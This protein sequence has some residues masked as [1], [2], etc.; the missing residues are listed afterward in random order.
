MALART[1]NGVGVS[2]TAGQATLL[3]LRFYDSGNRQA[4]TSTVVSET[5]AYAVDN[6]AQI[7]S[8][9]YNVDIFVGDP[10]YTAGLQYV[11]DQGALHFNSAGNGNTA[12]PPREVFEQSLFVANTDAADSKSFSSNYGE[13][14]DIA[15]P[16]SNIFSTHPGA[17]YSLKSGTSIAA[18]N[19]AGV[20]ALIWSH[21][22]TWT[23]E[24]VAAQ[25]LGTAD[26]IDSSNPDFVGLLGTGRVN[27][28][29]ALTS[30][31]GLPPVLSINN[32]PMDGESTD[33]A[34]VDEF[35]IS[36]DRIMEAAT[37]DDLSAY[38]LRSAGADR[39][40]DTLDDGLLSLAI[41]NNYEVG[42]NATIFDILSGP[43]GFGDYR[44]TVSGSILTDPFGNAIDGDADGSAGGDFTHFFSV[45]ESPTVPI[46]FAGGLNY[47]A[48]FV[49]VMNS[50]DQ[51]DLYTIPV[52]AGLSLSVVLESSDFQ[53]HIVVHDPTGAV[54]SDVIGDGWLVS[55][56]IATTIEGEYT[57]TITSEDGN[58]G[59]YTGQVILNA[60]F[61]FEHLDATLSNDDKANA[62][63]I[64]EHRVALGTTDADRLA[65][66]GDLN[67]DEDWYSFTL[68][69]GQIASIILDSPGDLTFELIGE[70]DSVLTTGSAHEE[71]ASVHRGLVDTTTDG[72]P[73]EYFVRIHSSTG[74]TDS[75]ELVV[76]RDAEFDRNFPSD[77]WLML[78]GA[79]GHIT[80]VVDENAEPDSAPTGAVL[81]NLFE[82]ITLS[83]NYGGSVF[84]SEADF[85]VTTGTHFF[86][87]SA[88]GSE[89]WQAGL[90]ELRIDFDELTDFVSIDVS[91][92]VNATR[93]FL[94]GYDSD[95]V[96]VSQVL[97]DFLFPG[98]TQTLTI[99]RPTADIEYVLAGGLGFVPVP[100]DNLVYRASG[101]EDVYKLSA[102]AG[103]EINV[104]GFLP[105][106]GQ[107]EF[108]NHLGDNTDNDLRFDLVAPDGTTLAS[109]DHLGFT[110]TALKTGV[111]DLVVSTIG[112]EGEYYVEVDGTTGSSVPT[113]VNSVT[114]VDG[115]LVIGFPTSV[116][117][118]FSSSLD[119]TT[120]ELSD[121]EIGGLPA[122]GFTAL[123]DQQFEFATD[124]AANSGFGTYEI[125]IAENVVV[126]LLGN[127]NESF[128]STFD[129]E[130]VNPFGRTGIPG[131]LAS[132]SLSNV[133]SISE[134][135]ERDSYS[136]F[137]ESDE[138]L[139]AIVTPVDP[140]ATLTVNIL[141]GT[142]YTANA[143]GEA[144]YLPPTAI[145]ISA[146][147]TVE[148]SGDIITEYE[149]EL[150]R[151]VGLH[152]ESE[153]VNSLTSTFIPLGSGRYAAIG[154]LTGTSDPAEADIDE[155]E[156]DLTG[157]VGTTFD[158]V[159]LSNTTSGGEVSLELIAPDG[160]VAATGSATAS[161]FEKDIL[162]F[163]IVQDGVY[164]VRVTSLES[165]DYQVLVAEDLVFDTEIGRFPRSLD[166][167]SG[168]FGYL[169]DVSDS[170][171][172]ELGAGDTLHVYT[173]TPHSLANHAPRNMLDPKLRLTSPDTET[174]SDSSS[175]DGVNAELFGCFRRRFL[176]D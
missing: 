10:V 112:R 155:F 14:I 96:F 68:D 22:P 44:L 19:A 169:S 32:L 109:S 17:T 79:L 11:Y 80:S 8:T 138:T 132:S 60:G 86:A 91:A 168:A 172:V 88:S 95:G 81:D 137:I 127:P 139:A 163:E 123:T 140:L 161:N 4:F 150:Y 82:G 176:F 25:L 28:F 58:A 116:I 131:S 158:I 73:S 78:N 31:V 110:Y 118:E 45:N 152:Q 113:V 3:P 93:G 9:S 117:L 175:R 52:D 145:E 125:S 130:E 51:V 49:G 144:V 147:M 70:D 33:S 108:A 90:D 13:G 83:N 64:N 128:T 124:P 129:V 56:S 89:G 156:L 153:A 72:I 53:P 40:F 41:R 76:L 2:G 114:P 74:A 12:N 142:I 71:F 24:M 162:D 102:N 99:E 15:A 18:P 119:E 48:D 38:E 136:F 104:A 1:D 101:G 29:N 98:Q 103:D 84:A 46:G 173:S 174:T 62:Q 16:G 97:G 106:G 63:S 165:G 171:E 35:S 111:Y 148:I 157:K 42:T 36:F 126:D 59:N 55:D 77:D 135:N 75:Y 105:G 20:A 30:T 37:V 57:V 65:V 164:L 120:L 170:Y 141:D 66:L 134:A 27:A 133:G 146:P 39:L 151:N 115:S 166:Q 154:E 67:E 26:N 85:D 107:Y 54:I 61:E 122:I 159:L 21:N 167:V 7:V 43:L 149:L 6:G 92:K 47:A 34:F 160:S 100:L 23:R 94:R 121:V 87:P 69:D 50:Q 143:P 5:Y